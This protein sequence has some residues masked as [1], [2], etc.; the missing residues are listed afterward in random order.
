MKHKTLRLF[1]YLLVVTAIFILWSGFRPADADNPYLSV[2]EYSLPS[3]ER[4]HLLT[5]GIHD[6][7]RGLKTWTDKEIVKKG[8]FW[9]DTNTTNPIFDN[10]SKPIGAVFIV[11]IQGAI[12]PGT[13]SF[14]KNSV[15][16]AAES[17][18]QALVLQLDTPGGLAESMRSMVKDILNA[19]IPIIVYVSPSGARA[20][21]AGVMVTMAADVAAMAPGTNI[22][23]AHPVHTG[24]QDIDG[25]MA[26]KVIN[27]MVAFL[28]GIAKERGRNVG[29]AKQAIE[30]SVSITASEAVRINVVDMQ[31]D[32]LDDLLQKIDGMEIRRGGLD[33]RLHTAGSPWVLLEETLRDRILRVLSDPNIA[34][35]LMMIGLAGLYF[36]LSN[37][38][39]IL[40]GVVGGISLILAFYS[41]QTLPV[42][43]AGVLLII[44]GLILFI[45][46]IKITSYGLLSIGGLISLTLGSLMLFDSPGE[47]VR[48]SLSVMIPVL[49]VVGGFFVIVTTLV[50]KAHAG[51]ATTGL[52]GM[53][54]LKGPVKEWNGNNGKVLVHGEWWQA[55][56]GEE[57]QP[58]DM[59]EVVRVDGLQLTV[60]KASI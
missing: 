43:Y 38:G 1:W 23:A 49:I 36:E 58:G 56:S 35:I 34:Y 12:S 11:R 44:I 47:Y 30:K 10:G 24:G 8:Q 59:I 7:F 51:Q 54:G 39:M 41:F 25:N 22:G 5:I 17:G 42:N 37:P 27:D 46:E 6:V 32:N 2:D 21:S 15:S 9:A 16:K 28:Q 13:A 3:L 19:P 18:A 57:L 14:F 45:M 50:I 20:A 60:K 31:A 29:W 33:V 40:P 4:T 55:V 53:V 48:I 26:D 52:D